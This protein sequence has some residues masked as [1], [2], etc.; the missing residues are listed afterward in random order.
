MAIHPPPFHQPACPEPTVAP[1]PATG[2]RRR[3]RLWRLRLWAWWVCRRS[4][5]AHPVAE[6]I[7]RGEWAALDR[8]LADL[9]EER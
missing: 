9:D 3:L 4:P 6:L 7:A 1:A 8:L 2:W 5:G